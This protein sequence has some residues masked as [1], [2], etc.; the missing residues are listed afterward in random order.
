MIFEQDPMLRKYMD[1]I[2]MH[3]LLTAEEEK[4]LAQISHNSNEDEAT[5]KAARDKLI[6]CNLRL[7]VKCALDLYYK[8]NK[9]DDANLGLMDLIQYGNIGLVRA[10]E[11]FSPE[12]NVRFGTYAYSGIQ[13]RMA[14]MVKESRFIRLPINHF[15]YIAQLKSLEYEMGDDLTDEIIMEKIGI[16]QNMLDLV[17]RNR[18]STLSL[19]ELEESTE[20]ILSV[21]QSELESDCNHKETKNYLFEKMKELSSRDRNILFMK[22]FGNEEVTLEIIGNKMGLTRERV[23]QILGKSLK[24]LRKIIEKERDVDSIM[25]VEIIEEM[26]K[27]NKPKTNTRRKY[28]NKKSNK[29]IEPPSN[30]R[31][32]KS[33]QSAAFVKSPFK[34]FKGFKDT[35]PS[36]KQLFERGNADKTS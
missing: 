29:S 18:G 5:R 22:Y 34:G 25:A 21:E 12:K 1:D 10:A 3:P 32:Y 6:F 31:N 7:V 4:S 36:V 33:R 23:R 9:M 16:D 19:D 13:R 17:K 8:V 20:Q 11:L 27:G 24:K 30:R 28:E 2:G 35:D 14:R 15:K 26:K